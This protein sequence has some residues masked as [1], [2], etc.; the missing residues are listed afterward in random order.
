M[1]LTTQKFTKG[2]KNCIYLELAKELGQR[3]C[4]EHSEAIATSQC[5]WG[6][7]GRRGLQL[8][9]A[10]PVENDLVNIHLSGVVH[11]QLRAAT[12]EALHTVT[13]TGFPSK[14]AVKVT[15]RILVS[16]AENNFA[17]QDG[18]QGKWFTLR[19]GII[20]CFQRIG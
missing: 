8:T 18:A 2:K 10:K 5:R 4:D 11:H 3:C 16:F 15:S 12:N 6:T 7:E 13:T 17:A 14:L 9:I 1:K 19:G 20:V